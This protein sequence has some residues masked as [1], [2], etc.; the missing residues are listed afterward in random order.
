MANMPQVSQRYKLSHGDA[1]SS[2]YTSTRAVGLGLGKVMLVCP[3]S[4]YGK[5]SECCVHVALVRLLQVYLAFAPTWLN[6][7]QETLWHHLFTSV[8]PVMW[9]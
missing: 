3:C 7:S 6:A 2:L 5:C 1:V 9:P 8:M 4:Q